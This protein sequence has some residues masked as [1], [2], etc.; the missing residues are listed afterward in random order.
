M[1]ILAYEIERAIKEAKLS[2]ETISDELQVDFWNRMA[3]KFDLNLSGQI[4]CQID[5]KYNEKNPDGWKALPALF[6]D[7]PVYLF[8]DQYLNKKIYKIDTSTDCLKLLG[9]CFSFVVY[10]ATPSL[11]KVSVFD[12]HDCLRHM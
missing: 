9:E 11:S 8:C 12:D 1:S 7:W 2:V 4:W 3:K 5:F 6:P 10:L